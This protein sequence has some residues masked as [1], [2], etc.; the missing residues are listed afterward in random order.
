MSYWGY[1]AEDS[2][3]AATAVG[4]NIYM[5]K[6]RMLQDIA[7]DPD[8]EHSEQSIL[9]HLL[10]LKLLGERFPKQLKVHF[11]KS[12]FLKAKE[13][14]YKWY[15]NSSGKIPNEFRQKFFSEAEKEFREIEERFYTK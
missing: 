3:F 7:N 14:F 10:C 8:R 1:K 4:A 12:D 2:D 15:E 9:G 6:K 13:S 11:R 5:I